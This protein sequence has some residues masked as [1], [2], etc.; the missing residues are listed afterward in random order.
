ML[1]DRSRRREAM[2]RIS[3]EYW[4]N[5]TIIYTFAPVAVRTENA[6]SLV[7]CWQPSSF[8]SANE[9]AWPSI[10]WETPRSRE[11][12]CIAPLTLN[13]LGFALFPAMPMR[14]IHLSSALTR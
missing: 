7:G 13:A 4:R 14:A 10:G 12:S 2:H 11:Y 1:G 9:A 6:K 5:I 3:M 8:T